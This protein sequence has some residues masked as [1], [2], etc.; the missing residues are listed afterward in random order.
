MRIERRCSNEKIMD[1]DGSGY[2]NAIYHDGMRQ[3]RDNGANGQRVFGDY[4]EPI[5][6]T[7]D[8]NA[9][10]HEAG[11]IPDGYENG[12]HIHHRQEGPQ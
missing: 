10:L 3:R 6:G 9:D 12:R 7:D 4:G 1:H 11:Q 5:R 2:L 8:H